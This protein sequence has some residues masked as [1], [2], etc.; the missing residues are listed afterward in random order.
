MT[1]VIDLPA[2]QSPVNENDSEKP[3]PDLSLN[4]Q[5]LHP[6]RHKENAKQF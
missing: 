5:V 4:S 2:K 1:M 6:F 3:T